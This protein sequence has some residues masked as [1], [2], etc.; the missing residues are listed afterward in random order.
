MADTGFIY[1]K[2]VEQLKHN[3]QRVLSE[4]DS[5]EE[6]SQKE[7]EMFERMKELIDVKKI[8]RLHHLLDTMQNNAQEA[9]ER[10]LAAYR[11]MEKCRKELD[12]DQ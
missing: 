3:F 2:E 8:E 9:E 6:G 10:A 12:L 4:L 1:G 11:D 5:M 7:Q